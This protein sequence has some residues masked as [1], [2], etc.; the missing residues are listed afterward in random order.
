MPATHRSST[1]AGRVAPRSMCRFFP[2]A[3]GLA[4]EAARIPSAAVWRVIAVAAAIAA[5]SLIVIAPAPSYDPW[6]WL[7]WGREVTEGG[8]DTRD[9]PA[10]KPL[11]VAVC[12]LLAP[13]GAAAP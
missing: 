3:P 11:P 4:R 6:M 10:F 13:L 7:L 9:G 1:S 5:L 12:A 2:M 8:L